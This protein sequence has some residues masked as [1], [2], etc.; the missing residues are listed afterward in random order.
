MRR[1][2][3][4]FFLIYHSGAYAIR[5]YVDNTAV[6]GFNDGTSWVDAYLNIESAFV[7]AKPGDVIW[8]AAGR[9]YAS[10]NRDVSY[11]LPNKV[12]VYGGFLRTEADES[13]RDL[14]LYKTYLDGDIGIKGNSSDN[15]RRILSISHTD[16]T[17]ILDGFHLVN[18]NND[19]V[20]GQGAALFLDSAFVSIRN[21]VFQNNISRG[22]GAGVY[23]TFGQRIEFISCS[24]I[25]NAVKGSFSGSG[26][27]CN[28]QSNCSFQSCVFNSNSCELMNG[29]AC[30]ATKKT[31]FY[32]CKFT[33]NK[34]KYSAALSLPNNK[35]NRCIIERCIFSN[36]TSSEGSGAAISFTDLDSSSIEINNSLFVGNKSKLGNIINI[37]DYG[38]MKSSFINNCTFSGNKVDSLSTVLIKATSSTYITNSIF[39]DN[40]VN[41]FLYFDVADF[42]LNP[43]VKSCIVEGGFAYGEKISNRNPYFIKSKSSQLAPFNDSGLNYRLN[44]GSY[45][46]D[47]GDSIF[48]SLKERKDLNRSTRVLKNNIDFG[49]YE[50]TYQNWTISVKDSLNGGYSIGAGVFPNDTMVVLVANEFS[51]SK[52]YAWME[53]GK[54]VSTD[55][56]YTFKADKNRKITAVYP[57]KQNTIN[58]IVKNGLLE[59]RIFGSGIFSCNDSMRTITASPNTCYRFVEWRENGFSVSTQPNLSIKLK[60]NREF[61]A[62]F[63]ILVPKLTLTSQ[64]GNAGVL[65]GGGIYNCQSSAHIMARAKKGFAFYAWRDKITG[66]NV[67]SDTMYDFIIN[68]N[69]ELVAIFNQSTGITNNTKSLGFY[70]N[71]C[72]DFLNLQFEILQYQIYNIEGQLIKS[73]KEQA[74]DV[75][76]LLPGIYLLEVMDAF[77]DM[78]RIKFVKE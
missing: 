55:S 3:L 60:T 6:T 61:E 73:G 54:I 64:P 51:C 7:K 5:I 44:I 72:H 22:S 57:Y 21:C 34:A 65:S 50:S 40:A 13:E 59:G 62:V 1:L 35:K 78:Q 42:G 67:T 45:A 20:I 63:E 37:N 70:P 41:K 12:A 68:T 77:G 49:A 56:I 8:V 18:A 32:D 30:V 4:L 15:S 33:S 38:K 10:S 16:S 27:A 9:I 43:K 17:T 39:W 76:S 31:A 11:K 28:I 24:F 74:I 69:R 71:P 47:G 14:T 23:A 19:F 52:F 66:N 25:N 2:L 75:K 36:N 48:L 46:V 58:V 29:G 53:N 26:G